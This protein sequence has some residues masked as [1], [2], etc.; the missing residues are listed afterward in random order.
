[1]L[2]LTRLPGVLPADPSPSLNRT[3]ADR[4]VTGSVDETV[5]VWDVLKAKAA[6]V[7]AAADGKKEEEKKKKKPEAAAV[8]THAVAKTKSFG[9]HHLGVVSVCPSAEVGRTAQCLALS[10]PAPCPGTRPSSTT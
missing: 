3:A 1:M 2:V 4:L 5:S 8:A 9:G 10:P 6:T 7:A